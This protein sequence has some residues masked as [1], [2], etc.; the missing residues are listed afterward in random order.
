MVLHLPTDIL[1]IMQTE[2]L[3]EFMMSH[4]AIL[5]AFRAWFHA[6]HHVT[7]GTGF[8]AD[9]ELYAEIYTAVEGYYDVVIEKSIGI[10]KCEHVASPHKVMKEACTVLGAYPD[11]VGMTSLAIATSA[12]KIMSDYS[13]FLNEM[14][15]GLEDMESITL[16]LDDF[17]A[18]T[19]NAIETYIYKLGQRIK[20][21]LQD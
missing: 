9:H 18:S 2:L 19:A 16:G 4:A 8:H 3:N 11:P 15:S 5:Q 21:E 1:I 20:T 17:H 10:L 13:D 12:H 6:A 7:R 14:N